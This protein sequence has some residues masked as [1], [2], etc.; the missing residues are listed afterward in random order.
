MSCHVYG[1]CDDELLEFQVTGPTTL[2]YAFL[3]ASWE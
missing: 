3:G 1:V 2:G